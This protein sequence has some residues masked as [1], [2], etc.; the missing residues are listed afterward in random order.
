[1][2]DEELE[3]LKNL[4][5]AADRMQVCAEMELV[6]GRNAR[7]FAEQAKDDGWKLLKWYEN[8]NKE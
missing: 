6:P 5:E 1:V 7:A 4:L 3:V 2:T 8:E